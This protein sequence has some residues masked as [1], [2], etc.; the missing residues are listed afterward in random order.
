MYSYFLSQIDR[1]F[2]I[3]KKKKKTL[4]IFTLVLKKLEYI[5]KKNAKFIKCQMSCFFFFFWQQLKF[6]ELLL[7]KFL[8]VLLV[9]FFFFV[10]ILF[11]RF[12]AAIEFNG[13][14]HRYF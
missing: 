6:L 5:L 3:T 2:E 9:F 4:I 1:H 12:L 13:I 10:Q 7:E 14:I 11:N 8:V